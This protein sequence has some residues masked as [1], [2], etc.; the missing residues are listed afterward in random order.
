M[1]VVVLVLDLCALLGQS[2]AVE[3]EH[4]DEDDRGG[5]LYPR[6]IFEVTGALCSALKQIELGKKLLLRP[7]RH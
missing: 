3:H 5:K 7:S 1:L 6:R 2:V 4:D